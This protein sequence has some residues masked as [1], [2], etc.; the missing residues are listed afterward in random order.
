MQATEKFISLENSKRYKNTGSTNKIQRLQLFKVF[1][2]LNIKLLWIK[3]ACMTE[4]ILF[5][6]N[7]LNNNKRDLVAY[8]GLT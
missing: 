1:T 3:V 4:K 2:L 6:I 8:R 7:H 5:M